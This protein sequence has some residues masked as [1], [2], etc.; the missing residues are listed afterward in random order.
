MFDRHSYAHISE[1]VCSG[2]F[3][4]FI[5]IAIKF[6]CHRCGEFSERVGVLGNSKLAPGEIFPIDPPNGTCVYQRGVY[7]PSSPPQFT[8]G[9][10]ILNVIT[11]RKLGRCNR[12]IIQSDVH[13]KR[14][15]EKEDTQVFGF[16]QLI[17]KFFARSRVCISVA[18]YWRHLFITGR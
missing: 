10:C 11:G 15:L 16:S 13:Q 7:K 18:N 17:D 14:N 4:F 8:H 3:L 5:N 1:G 9:S 12:I 6:F 2:R